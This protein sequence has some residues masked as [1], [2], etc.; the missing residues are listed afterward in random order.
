MMSTPQERPEFC[1]R[2]RVRMQDGLVQLTLVKLSQFPKRLLM[3]AI[4]YSPNLGLV[5]IFGT[6]GIGHRSDCEQ[7]QE[8]LRNQLS[9]LRLRPADTYESEPVLCKSQMPDLPGDVAN[10]TGRQSKPL[11]CW[12]MIEKTDRVLASEDDLLDG[13]LKSGHHSFSFAGS[14]PTNFTAR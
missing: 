9:I 12:R 1:L 14:A 11:V 10:S 2:Q 8:L 3:H 13:Q 4:K 6:I 7:A 5:R